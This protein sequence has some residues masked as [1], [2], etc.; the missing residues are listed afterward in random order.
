MADLRFADVSNLPI[1]LVDP[2]ATHTNFMS[3]VHGLKKCCPVHALTSIHVIFQGLI[4]EFWSNVVVLRG[5]EDYVSLE[6]TVKG[7][8]ICVT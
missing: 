8:K 6:A 7:K 5:E 1:F 4:N 2:P 3:R